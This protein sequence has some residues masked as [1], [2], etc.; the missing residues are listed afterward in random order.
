MTCPVTA[1]TLHR[2]AKFFMDSGRADSHEDA[3]DILITFGLCISVGPEVFSSR[4]HQIALLTLVNLA[5]RTFLGG[6]HIAGVPEAPLLAPLAEATSLSAA[7]KELGGVIVENH[8]RSWPNVYV[9]SVEE[10]A[11]AV[12]GWQLTWEGW[13]GGV[14]PLRERRR[15]SE[16]GCGGIAPA[17]AAAA[18]ACEAFLYYTN[19]HAMAGLRSS[20]LSL[21]QPEQGWLDDDNT[22]PIIQFLPSALW[23]IGLGNL[24]QAYLWCLACLPYADRRAVKL[25]LQDFDRITPA[26]ESTSILTSKEMIGRLKTRAVGEWLEKRSFQVALEERHFG[27][28]SR[29][30]PHDPAVALCGVDNTSARSALE[31]AGFDLVIE[32]GLGSEPE[33][34]QS[35]SLHTFPSSLSAATLWS[36]DDRPQSPRPLARAYSQD[37][38][39]GLDQCGIVQLASRSIA[40]PFVGLAAALFAISELLR[41]LHGGT[42]LQLVSASVAV[43]EDVETISQEVG[44]YAFGYVGA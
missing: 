44:P 36:R 13:R 24:G 10:S 16:V 37:K 27:E 7:L 12:F 18:C 40:V 34:F 14:T 17:F 30:G 6:V 38:L 22:E 2:T 1:D 11:N 26:N 3:I 15:L 41:R 43:L 28:W 4:D 42:A 33:A 20:G 25:V 35:F 8:E 21:W 5:G 23:L 39:P 31:H 19:S 29:R 32:T 9:G